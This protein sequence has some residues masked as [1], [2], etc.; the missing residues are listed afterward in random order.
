MTTERGWLCGKT[1]LCY[2][3]LCIVRVFD[4]KEKT[5][6]SVRNAPT[7]VLLLSLTDNPCYE[8][9]CIVNGIIPISAIVAVLCIDSLW[10][11]RGGEVYFTGKIDKNESKRRETSL[12]PFSYSKADPQLLSRWSS[13]S[14]ILWRNETNLMYDWRPSAMKPIDNIQSVNP[15]GAGKISTLI[16]LLTATTAPKRYV[17]TRVSICSKTGLIAVLI[18]NIISPPINGCCSN[19][20]LSDL[21]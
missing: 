11:S 18:I 7:A 10:E 19:Q 1:K 15:T 12:V 3:V 9:R 20:M 6:R 17:C 13:S 8:S 14:S 5:H 2:N 16:S 21:V 4:C